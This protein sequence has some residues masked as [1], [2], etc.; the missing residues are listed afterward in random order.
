MKNV[1]PNTTKVAA[2]PDKI[3]RIMP[4]PGVASRL[5]SALADTVRELSAGPASYL[6]NALLPEISP[7]WFP[8]RLALL[9]ASSLAHPIEALRGATAGDALDLKRRRR[10]IPIL[11]VSAGVHGVLIIYLIYL[12]FFSPF[13]HVRMVNK[14]YR[15]FDPNT[16]LAK[17][18]YPPQ[19]LRAA[20]T[21]PAMTLEEIRARAEKHKHELALAREKAEKEKKEK[22]EAD[23][24]AAEEAAKVAAQNKP[25]TPTKFGEIN[26]APIKDTVAT[27]YALFQAG[28]LDI[29]EMKFS[30]MAGFK[31]EP[32]GSLSN[33]HIK[34]HSE[35]KVIDEKALEILWKIGESHALGPVSDLTSATISLDVTEDIARLRITAFAPTPE[36][37]K[38]KADMLGVLFW[39]LRMKEKSPDIGQLL[40]L[41]K[42]KSDGKRVD[43]DLVVPRAKAAEM[44]RARF[45]H[46]GTPPQ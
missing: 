33:I 35:S 43:T 26:E 20:P 44:M 24:K 32:D 46:P 12:A 7:D 40:S 45:E 4:L 13:A 29:P 11:T 23:R 25:A 15:K 8:I 10:F 34:R 17:L 41:I 19:I 37:A 28:G 18:Y 22:E 27:L 31:V 2:D 39:A 30:V 5:A 36:I 3:I 42:V 6:R 9:V 14:A 1:A 38:A 16:I 21:G